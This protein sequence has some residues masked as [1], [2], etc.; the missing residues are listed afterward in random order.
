MNTLALQVSANA[1]ITGTLGIIGKDLTLDT[2]AIAGATYPAVST[3]APLDS[4]T[5]AMTEG[6]GAVAVVTEIQLNLDNGMAARYVVGSKT[7]IHP[8][9]GRSNI[10]GTVTVFFEDAD[11]LLKFINETESSMAFTL[12]DG[13]GN[14]YTFTVPRL[15]Y[16]GGQPDVGGEGP[17]TLAMPF[18]ALRDAVSGSN[19]IIKRTPA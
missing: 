12:P 8:S 18:Q 11:M 19:I 10:T 9:I 16:S 6:G 1:I 7:T 4:F 3:T 17:I 5:G 15:K 14:K 13:A 2:A